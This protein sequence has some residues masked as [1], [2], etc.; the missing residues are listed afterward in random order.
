MPCIH[1]NCTGYIFIDST[2]GVLLSCFNDDGKQFRD[3]TPWTLFLRAAIILTHTAYSFCIAPLGKGQ[4]NYFS[5]TRNRNVCIKHTC[6]WS[7]HEPIN[8]SVNPYA[9][10]LYA[11]PIRWWFT[12]TCDKC[13]LYLWFHL[14]FPPFLWIVY[15]HTMSLFEMWLRYDIGHSFMPGTLSW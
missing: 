15:L 6:Q 8:H 5:E 4:W 14:F 2:V 7:K 13:I 3:N 10:M 1:S 9:W 11:I 12:I